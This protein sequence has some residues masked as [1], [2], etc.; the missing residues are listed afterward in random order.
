[1]LALLAV[2]VAVLLACRHALR[3]EGAVL[4]GPPEAEARQRLTLETAAWSA[5]GLAAYT[6]AA[7]LGAPVAGAP[8]VAPCAVMATGA[9]A[10]LALHRI[11][12]A[13]DEEPRRE[14]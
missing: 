9:F 4:R 2:A 12:R 13:K 10:R 11:G 1:M 6:L 7:V 8:I 3:A 14:S 5:A